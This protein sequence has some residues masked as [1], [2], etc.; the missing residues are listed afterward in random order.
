ML[1][2]GIK[3]KLNDQLEPFNV[4]FDTLSKMRHLLWIKS[5]ENKTID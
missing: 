3:M 4:I 2:D 1:S 5:K